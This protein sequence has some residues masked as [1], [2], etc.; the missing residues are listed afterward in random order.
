M[1]QGGPLTPPHSRVMS[2]SLVTAGH[3]GLF[4]GLLVVIEEYAK[5][6]LVRCQRGADG[7]QSLRRARRR[8]A[9][10]GVPR[11]SP[12]AEDH[13]VARHGVRAPGNAST[14]TREV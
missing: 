2:S 5:E 1:P 8:P 12:G 13:P 10:A 7:V 14:Q 4:K 6:P 9:C 3:E 11:A